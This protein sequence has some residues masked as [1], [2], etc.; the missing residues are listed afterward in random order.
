MKKENQSLTFL[1]EKELH[2]ELKFAAL[3]HDTS[4][5]E[6]LAAGAR[7]WLKQNKK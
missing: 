7:E 6:I 1:I 5:K 2:K 4:M 3:K